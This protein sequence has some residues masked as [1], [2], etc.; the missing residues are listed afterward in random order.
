MVVFSVI[1]IMKEMLNPLSNS[2]N[3]LSNNIFT[4]LKIQ[5]SS[6]NGIIICIHMLIRTSHKKKGDINH[7]RRNKSIIS[8]AGITGHKLLN[9]SSCGFYFKAF[10]LLREIILLLNHIISC[11]SQLSKWLI[12][13]NY[14]FNFMMIN[15]R[16]FGYSVLVVINFSIVVYLT[17]NM[18]ISQRKNLTCFYQSYCV[19]SCW[20]FM[21]DSNGGEILFFCVLTLLIMV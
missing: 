21:G 3:F 8:L 7:Q 17:S 10:W 12:C 14:K 2:F 16:K 11:C 18:V 20:S 1:C 15:C 9:M 4:N 5:P 13:L 19:S 6:L